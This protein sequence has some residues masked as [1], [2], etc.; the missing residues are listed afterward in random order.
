MSRYRSKTRNRI[1]VSAKDAG[2]YAA[3]STSARFS[4]RLQDSN[5]TLK[6]GLRVRTRRPGSMAIVDMAGLVGPMPR[7]GSTQL[8]LAA[9]LLAGHRAG[10]RVAVAQDHLETAGGC[11]TGSSLYSRPLLAI[12]RTCLD[13]SKALRAAPHKLKSSTAIKNRPALTRCLAIGGEDLSTM[14]GTA[15]RVKD[16]SWHGDTACCTSHPDARAKS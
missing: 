3:A 13:L 11:R 8:R 16:C 5:Q 9:C 14:S 7:T 2:S 15:R 4:R 12:R 10:G 1:C 6:L